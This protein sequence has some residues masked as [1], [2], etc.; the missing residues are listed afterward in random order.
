MY[1]V[2]LLRYSVGGANRLGVR[3][4]I[5]AILNYLCSGTLATFQPAT[6]KSRR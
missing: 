4:F 2:A 3:Y 5:P 1:C 6:D